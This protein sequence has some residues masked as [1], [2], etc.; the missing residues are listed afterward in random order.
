MSALGSWKLWRACDDVE[1]LGSHP[2]EARLPPHRCSWW[3]NT[4]Q[5]GLGGTPERLCSHT[6]SRVGLENSHSVN[7][8]PHPAGAL[9]PLQDFH[10]IQPRKNTPRASRGA[11]LL[12]FW[13]HFTLGILMFFSVV[14][15]PSPIQGAP[16][17]STEQG[18]EWH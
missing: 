7:P 9:C 5:W 18:K 11:E 1:C 13:G 4:R 2:E 16:V 3:T 14:P 8:P 15:T 6:F 17:S 12:L 10:S